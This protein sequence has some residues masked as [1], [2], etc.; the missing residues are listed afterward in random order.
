M[1]QD[2]LVGGRMTKAVRHS[3]KER[4]EVMYKQLIPFIQGS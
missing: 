1:Y 4:N 3:Q 2:L